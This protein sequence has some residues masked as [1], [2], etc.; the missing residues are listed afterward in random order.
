MSQR[1]PTLSL[2]YSKSNANAMNTS[3]SSIKCRMLPADSLKSPWT[4]VVRKVA[5]L[6]ALN[7]DAAAV[8]EKLVDDLLLSEVS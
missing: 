1:R 7:V 5:R 3:L 6:E 8:I 4:R 2:V